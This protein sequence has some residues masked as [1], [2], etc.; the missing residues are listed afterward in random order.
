MSF[1]DTDAEKAYL[2]AVLM[3]PGRALTTGIAPGDLD[4][5]RGHDK[6]L[7]AVYGV[8]DR[9]VTVDEL[10]ILD[11][12]SRDGAIKR[13]GPEDRRG[14]VYLHDLIDSCPTVANAEFYALK[15]REAATRRKIHGIGERLKQ[16]AHSPNHDDLIET[17]A[18]LSLA[19]EI[20][21]EEP[22]TDSP[23]EDLFDL[24][25]FVDQ[26]IPD[27][28]WIVP[29]LLGREERVI[30][31]ATEG[32]GKSFLTRQFAVLLASG[33]HPFEPSIDI[34]AKRTLLVDCEN[35]PD[36]VRK[37]TRPMVTKARNLGVWSDGHAFCWMK[38]AGLDLRR[39]PDQQL[40]DRVIAETRPEL[41]CIGPLYKM[42]TAGS[43]SYEQT[44]GEVARALDRLRHKH[45]VALWIEH[46]MPKEQNGTRTLI[47]FGS[48]LWQRW[49]EFGRGMV[50]DKD[51]PGLWVMAKFRPDRDER[52]WPI[53]LTR[54]GD[55]PWTAVWND[56]DK[57][58]LKRL[59]S[60]EE[61]ALWDQ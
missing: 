27:Q 37:K 32:S 52:L 59:V 55:W 42:F 6:I 1:Y 31:V 8:L 22:L 26:P 47:P 3:A 12:L 7:T 41:V 25:E 9:G 13:V 14:A 39:L 15:I 40:L 23:I 20:A 54:G 45:G 28:Q 30:F 58:R 24:G 2:G 57:G 5:A 17:A 49:P 33:R 44:A 11:A 43:D 56:G 4:P 46:H 19:L 29:G 51:D 34:P 60:G 21:V 35:P 38:P 48:S 36:L 16:V 18:S 50:L 10:V 53:G 61:A